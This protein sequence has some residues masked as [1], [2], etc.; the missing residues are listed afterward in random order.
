MVIALVLDVRKA[1]FEN[2]FQSM[3]KCILLIYNL[4]SEFFTYQ[5]NFSKKL[6]LVRASPIKPQ[7]MLKEDET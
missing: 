3:K 2:A 4:F 7:H 1:W 5:N 6:P